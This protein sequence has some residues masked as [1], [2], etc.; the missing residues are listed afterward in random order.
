MLDPLCGKA[1]TLFCALE[2]GDNAVGVD[3]D[4]K[5][6]NEADD[7]FERFLKLNRLKHK[8]E[9]TALTLPGGRSAGCAAYTAADTA[10]HYK[11]GDRRTL[12]LIRGDLTDLPRLLRPNSCHL[13][14]G[15]L[16]YG[17]QHAPR[18]GQRMSSLDKLAR[19]VS[20]GCAAVLIKGGAAAFSFNTYT[21]SRAR[22]IEAMAAAGLTPLDE[23]PY[24][25]FSHWVEQAVDR[26]AVIGLKK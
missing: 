17:I 8:R 7:Y 16:P 19:Q 3:V 26:D 25:G 23:P 2:E 14:V 11:A 6:L 15:D 4:G 20:E 24:N 12:R 1:T 13:A 22:M 9:S 21:L 10:E 5:A 18:E